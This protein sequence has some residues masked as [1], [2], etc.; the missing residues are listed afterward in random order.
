[1]NRY[2]PVGFNL[3]FSNNGQRLSLALAL[4]ATVAT[5]F[6]TTS[7]HASIEPR[8]VP[9]DFA[10]GENGEGSVIAADLDGSGVMD[11]VV[12]APGKIGAYRQDG[13]RVW[14]LEADVRVS[15]GSSE[16]R[17][18][19]GHHAP[20]VQ[21]AD[22]EGNSQPRLLYLD[23][24]ST[25]HIHDA[26][27]GTKVR[28]VRVP[29]PAGAERWEHLVV[30]NL[31]GQG[32]RDVVLQATNAKGYRVGRYVAAYAIE[33]LEG[34]PL[35]QTDHFGALAH[36]PFR[37]ADLTGD[38][39][40]EICGFTLLSP[41]GK[42]TDWNYPPISPE[43]GKGRSFHIDGLTIEDVRPDV[44]GLEVV[45]LEEGRNYV[46]VVNFE[47][48]L[49]WW[50]TRHQEEPQNA[51]VGE[52]DPQRPGLEIWNRSRH[53]RNQTP[54]VFDARG[55]VIAEYPMSQVAPEGWTDAGVEVIVPI[56]WTGA[57]TQLIAAKERHTRGDVA[58]IEPLTGRFVL[59]LK[60]QADRLYVA[61]VS[62][63][64]REEIIVI[65]G[66]ELRVYE[67]PDPN[68]RPHQPRLWE[69]QHYRRNK[70]TWNYYS[71]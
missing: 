35:W 65:N 63:D 52:F 43:F 2:S 71:P 23:Q 20:G 17:G 3:T 10:V 66:R 58:V 11:F 48:G 12:T 1:M 6:P 60:E 49:L 67:N 51:A 45:L 53:N 28:S 31:R 40:D 27:T 47:R 46:G 56:H 38:G 32:D 24:A 30:A 8:V 7:V 14:L 41:E 44:P 62:G 4:L 57:P 61:D 54:W 50:E 19:P 42:S 39:R 22:I 25:V 34:K 26:A 64:W 21:V 16:S 13:E 33:D 59:R 5:A 70:M 18:L 69:R 55:Q 29:H 36:G 9:L 15:A 68:P 37:V